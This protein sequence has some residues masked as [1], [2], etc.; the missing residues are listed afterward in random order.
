VLATTKVA[1]KS[2]KLSV[3]AVAT[4]VPPKVTTIPELPSNPV[5]VTLTVILFFPAEVLGVMLILE[6]TL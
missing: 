2:P 6:T 5:P 4:C 3:V 1:V